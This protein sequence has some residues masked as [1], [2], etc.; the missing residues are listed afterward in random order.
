MSSTDPT[1]AA[2]AWRIGPGFR[3]GH[4]EGAPPA[5]SCASTSLCVVVNR[6]EAITST[7]PLAADPTWSAPTPIVELRA[8]TASLRGSP[9]TVGPTLTFGLNCVG[10]WIEECRGAATITA[11]ERLARNGRTVTGVTAAAKRARHRAVVIGRATFATGLAG[12]GK[13]YTFKVALNSTG[14]H[15]LAKFKRLPATLSVTAVAREF[16]V[17]AKTIR[18]AT[19]VVTFRARSARARR[20]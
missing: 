16:R 3:F 4:A 2:P 9:A 11:T 17:P 8:G 20:I 6:Q 7:N 10:E 12:N 19:S 15:L 1:E 14:R 13:R 5:V 18:V